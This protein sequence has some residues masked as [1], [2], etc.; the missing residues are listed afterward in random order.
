MLGYSHIQIN[1][2]WTSVSVKV[3]IMMQKPADCEQILEIKDKTQVTIIQ[4]VLPDGLKIQFNSAGT[5]S[6]R[7]KAQ[8]TE[9]VD[10]IQH[11]D[12][13]NEWE[14]RAVDNIQPGEMVVITGKG[15]G[16]AGTFQGEYHFMTGSKNLA[17]L[18]NT[19]GYVEGAVDMTNM[20]AVMKVFAV[21]E[22]MAAA[23]M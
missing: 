7:Y 21:K 4:A 5:T 15:V 3:F 10:I 8:H 11:M 20:E 2:L 23:P 9:T 18:N 12:G 16:Q 19:T 14:S 17:W 1:R 22:V 6:G 13:T